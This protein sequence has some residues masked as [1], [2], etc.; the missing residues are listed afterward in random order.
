MLVA[1]GARIDAVCE[2]L[3]GFIPLLTRALEPNVRISAERDQL[4]TVKHAILE[5]PQAPASRCD[6]EKKAALIVELVRFLS[7]FGGANPGVA[8][9]DYLTATYPTWVQRTPRHTPTQSGMVKDCLGQP[10]T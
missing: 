8:Q 2:K 10:F 7:R 9:H 5:P 3:T 1:L 6:E 4:L